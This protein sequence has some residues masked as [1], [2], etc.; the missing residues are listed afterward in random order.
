V[1][2]TSDWPHRTGIAGETSYPLKNIV[3]QPTKLSKKEGNHSTKSSKIT[4]GDDGDLIFF[5]RKNHSPLKIPKLLL[6]SSMIS[7]TLRV[8]IHFFSTSRTRLNGCD[9]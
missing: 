7:S 2:T 6:G 8:S 5:P 1:N 4:G 9:S 3:Y